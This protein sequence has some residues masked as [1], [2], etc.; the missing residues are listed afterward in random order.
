M[1]LI[2]TKRRIAVLFILTTTG[3]MP[4]K[5]SRNVS[6]LQRI[7]EWRIQQ[8]DRVEMEQQKKKETPLALFS[9]F[10]DPIPLCVLSSFFLLLS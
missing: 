1:E 4:F 10:D 3:A 8:K 6:S 2:G 9:F 7:G 5:F